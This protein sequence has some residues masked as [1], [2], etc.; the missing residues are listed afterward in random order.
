VDTSTSTA[1][2]LYQKFDHL[3]ANIAKHDTGAKLGKT[4][5]PCQVKK[6]RF[7]VQVLSVVKKWPDQVWVKVDFDDG[8]GDYAAMPMTKEASAEHPVDGEGPKKAVTSIEVAGWDVVEIEHKDLSLPGGDGTLV[9]IKIKPKPW[10]KFDVINKETGKIEPSVK[11]KLKLPG[12]GDSEQTTAAATID[13][14]NLEAG[15][16]DLLQLTHD[17]VWECVDYVEE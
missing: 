17:K 3:Q 1:L 10:I 9:K 5:S 6:W 12:V 14:P 13:I 11:L 7:R 8:D 15:A 16:C 2:V 4:E